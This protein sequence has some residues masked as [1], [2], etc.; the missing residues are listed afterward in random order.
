MVLK[1]L[2]LE[3]TKLSMAEFMG[4]EEQEAVSLGGMV[5]NM[6][7]HLFFIHLADLVCLLY[8]SASMYT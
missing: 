5:W 6:Y 3:Q 1:R 8:P 7:V 4:Q 2:Q